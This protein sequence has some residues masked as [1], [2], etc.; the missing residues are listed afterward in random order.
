[1]KKT[2]SKS[3]HYQRWGK[4]Q[5]QFEA[6][7]R[8]MIQMRDKGATYTAIGK[9]FNVSKDRARVIC[10]TCREDGE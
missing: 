1:M 10:I 8:K 3:W 5:E 2:K 4:T 9:K 6:R 7:N